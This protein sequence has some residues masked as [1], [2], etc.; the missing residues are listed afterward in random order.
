[1]VDEMYG[2]RPAAFLKLRESAVTAA[3]TKDYLV[4]YLEG[5]L[6]RFKI[7]VFFYHWPEGLEEDSLKVKRSLFGKLCRQDAM[8]PGIFL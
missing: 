3:V 5:K 6:P 1:V 8:A 2:F 7:P 4:S